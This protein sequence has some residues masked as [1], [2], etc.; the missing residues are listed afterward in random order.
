MSIGMELRNNNYFVMAEKG[1]KLP[2]KTKRKEIQTTRPLEASS[3]EP[4]LRIPFREGEKDYAADRNRLIGALEIDPQ[5]IRRD[6]PIGTKMEVML[7]LKSAGNISVEVYVPILDES[8]T[9]DFDPKKKTS[10]VSV[11]AAKLLIEKQ[12]LEKLLQKALLLK[13]Q[14]IE[15]IL[16]ELKNSFFLKDLEQSIKA[17]ARDK[18]AAEKS[19]SRL[20]EFMQQLDEAEGH[21]EW[22]DLITR[23][24]EVLDE[25]KNLLK[26]H[27]IKQEKTEE[28]DDLISAG[29]EAISHKS[30][31]DLRHLISKAEKTIVSIL[32]DQP[33]FWIK[34]FQNFEARKNQMIDLT[35]A[36]VLFREGFSARDSGN[37]EK[38]KEVVRGLWK[39]LPRDKQAEIGS[40]IGGDFED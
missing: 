26:A 34:L 11:L 12:R 5:M 27:D 14:H 8:F 30:Q 39:L 4:A 10:D 37:I 7:S 24:R 32:V 15:K 16:A 28:I 21:L 6:L 33:E 22:P 38:I 19:D 40:F 29:E 1:V 17:A 3:K 35:K 25:A 18:V 31:D 36:N 9:K 20:C 23:W 2:F 13:E